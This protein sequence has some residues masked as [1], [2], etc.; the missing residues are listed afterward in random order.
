MGATA[1]KN[2]TSM[3]TREIGRVKKMEKSPREE[4]RDC[5]RFSSKMGPKTTARIKG[6]ASKPSRFTAKPIMPKKIIKN[7]SKILLFT[8]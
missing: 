5:L 3:N 6:A 1:R 4:I 8:L 7:I 2:V